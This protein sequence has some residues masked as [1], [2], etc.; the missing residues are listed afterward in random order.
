MNPA[1]DLQKGRKP[2]SSATTRH[3]LQASF[4]NALLLL[5][6]AAA[7]GCATPALWK[8]TAARNWYPE[9]RPDLFLAATTTG[10]LDLIVVFHQSA[11]VGDKTKQRL[12]AWNLSQPPSELTI[13]PHAL[14]QLTNAYDRVQIVPSF[15][16]DDPITP[17]ASSAT[18]GYVVTG[19]LRS[20]FTLHLD[21][22]CPG[23][24]DLPYTRQ[25]TR[26]LERVAIMPFSVA[27]DAAIVAAVCCA[28][29]GYGGPGPIGR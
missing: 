13:G 15:T 9:H 3:R 26:V 12:V 2:A 10:R 24:F 25:D 6:L 1:K 22:F 17:R 18:P 28:G 8:H 27:A 16:S 29:A 21:G 20:Q 4:T 23:P 19:P 7:T 11:V 5:P 14:R